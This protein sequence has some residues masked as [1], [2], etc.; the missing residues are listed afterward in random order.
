MPKIIGESLS[1]H[2]VATR[3]RLFEALAELLADQFLESITMAQL[4]ARAGIG[5]TAVY[6]HFADKEAVVV[7]FATSETDRFMVTLDEAL[8]GVVGA[9]ER[10]RTY[11][12]HYQQNQDE[13]HLSLG[14]QVAGSLSEQALRD[15][16]THV[17]MVQDALAD[18]ITE[19]VV[20]EDFAA[21]DVAATVTLVHACLQ[22]TRVESGDVENFV[23][24][25]LARGENTP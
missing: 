5:R 18:I 22:A 20:A 2:R 10:L 24:R 25:A 19:G 9:T 14:H 16:R 21:A 15:M 23:I 1:E 6:N 12:R 11:V 8:D 13:F 7:A 17:V 4:A 3:A